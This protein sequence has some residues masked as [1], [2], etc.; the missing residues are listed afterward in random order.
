MEGILLSPKKCF[1]FLV[2]AVQG[3]P[4]RASLAGV[5]NNAKE[6]GFVTRQTKWNYKFITSKIRLKQ[7]KKI[8][9]IFFIEIIIFFNVETN[10]KYFFRLFFM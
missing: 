6:K 5:A 2:P 10:E 9:S 7:C 4:G 3:R 1:Y 8:I